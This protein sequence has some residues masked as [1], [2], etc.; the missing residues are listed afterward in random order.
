[1]PNP[2]LPGLTLGPLM[3]DL[4]RPRWLQF[5]HTNFPKK[6]STGISDVIIRH[7]TKLYTAIFT[8]WFMDGGGYWSFSNSEFCF[9][10]CF[11]QDAWGRLFWTG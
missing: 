9:D 11:G 10:G 8:R 7:N 3:V 5:D 2:R 6:L 4:V 1:M